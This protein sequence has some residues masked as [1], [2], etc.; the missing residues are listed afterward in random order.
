MANNGNIPDMQKIEVLDVYD[1]TIDLPGGAAS[2]PSKA[3]TV[4]LTYMNPLTSKPM[5]A[6]TTMH[7]YPVNGHWA[8]SLTPSYYQAYVAG[9]CPTP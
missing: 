7:A 6:T 9:N 3:V 4:R 1:E 8:W 5:T 2:T